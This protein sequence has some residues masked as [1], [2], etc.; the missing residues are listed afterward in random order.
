MKTNRSIMSIIVRIFA[1]FLF[2]LCFVGCAD[3][4]PKEPT[5]KTSVATNETESIEC[6][7]NYSAK[8]TTKATCTKEG[9][10]THTC[11]FCGDSYTSSIP[12]LSTH[13]YKL[14]TSVKSTCTSEGTNKYQCNDCEKSYVEKVAATGHKWKEATCTQAQ[15]CT[16]CNT[17]QGESLGHSLSAGFCSRCDYRDKYY[18]PAELSDLLIETLADILSSVEGGKSFAEHAQ[19]AYSEEIFLDSAK[20][21]AGI[22]HGELGI[23][24]ISLGTSDLVTGIYLKDNTNLLTRLNNALNAA[25]ILT[26]YPS[27]S[28]FT[29]LENDLES[30]IACLKQV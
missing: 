8:I 11:K 13:N 3:S 18:M 17:T 24:I 25:N 6:K 29:N 10:K 26:V 21:M 2:A 23:L 28:G 4:Q 27:L 12:V 7:H 15:I 14:V 1:L 22:A 20:A 16:V 5:N 19:T 9:V 30:I